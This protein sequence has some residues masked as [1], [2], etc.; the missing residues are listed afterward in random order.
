M[1]EEEIV[2]NREEGV[3]REETREKEEEEGKDRLRVRD[4]PV[5]SA[6]YWV[7]KSIEAQRD[8]YP[9]YRQLGDP[10]FSSLP[11]NRLASRVD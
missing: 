11:V 6:N 9:L 1:E 2:R 3:V 5:L 4:G 10:E 8:H 7:Q